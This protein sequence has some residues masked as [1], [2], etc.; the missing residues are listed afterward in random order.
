MSFSTL[1]YSLIAGLFPSL[2]WLWFWTREDSNSEPRSLLI[3]LFLGGFLAVLGAIFAEQ[4]IA[5]LGLNS[6]LK[7]TLWAATEEIFK[8]VAVA[9][10]ALNSDYNDEPIDAM[11]YCI[12]TA[13]GFAALENTLFLLTPLA[14]GG[15]GHRPPVSVPVPGY[16]PHRSLTRPTRPARG[17]HPGPDRRLPCLQRFP[18]FHPKSSPSS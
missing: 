4:Y 12:V 18:F 15:P 10:V 13:L 16:G 14:G 8:F 17:R 1:A 6:S 3:G 7:Y 9:V 5:S 2:I 11:I